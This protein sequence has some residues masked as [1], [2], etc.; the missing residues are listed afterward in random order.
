MKNLKC[1]FVALVAS[2]ALSLSAS[3]AASPSAK[4]M[5]FSN[6]AAYAGLNFASISTSAPAEFNGYTSAL[7]GIRASTPI[8]EPLS[9]VPGAQIVNR[10]FGTRTLGL[11]TTIHLTYL[12]FPLLVVARFPGEATSVVP[13]FMAGPNLGIKL[14]SGCSVDGASSCSITYSNFNTLALSLDL[15]AGV[16]FPMSNGQAISTEFRY[17]HE[18]TSFMSAGASFHHRGV[19][20]VGA[21]HF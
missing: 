7:I 2:S 18:L 14:G 21:F 17:H 9:F 10:G 5:T 16:E 13:Y 20:L 4:E 1:L 6:Y 8:S 15:G 11:D 19:E 12:E 3:A